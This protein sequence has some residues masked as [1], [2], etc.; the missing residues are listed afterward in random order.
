MIF[1]PV[2]H[3]YEHNKESYV[4][5]TTF[6]KKFKPEFKKEL[7][8][9]QCAKRDGREV[10]ELLAQWE[11]NSE[12]SSMYGTVI[13]KAV[14]YWIRYG[15]FSKLPFL[16]DL[17]EKFAAK[18]NRES[19]VPEIIVFSEALRLA[20]TIDQLK[21]LGDKKVRVMDVKTNAELTENSRGYFLA[22]LNKLPFSKINEYRLQLSVYKYLLE[23]KGIMVESLELEH[24]NG[25]DFK[26]IQLEPIN[27]ESLLLHI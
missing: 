8:A 5:V 16:K 1:E 15:E 10:T 3:T 26:T 21:K 25:E 18:H 22:P 24:W 20:G 23:A 14:E 4:S 6:L 19:L 17:V 13:H 2:A 27:V 7:V 12:I 11:L 9:E